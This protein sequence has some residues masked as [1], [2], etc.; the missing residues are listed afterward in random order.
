MTVTHVTDFVCIPGLVATLTSDP[1]PDHPGHSGILGA[2]AGAFGPFAT[3]A[4]AHAAAT[5]A[6]FPTSIVIPRITRA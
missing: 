2:H 1:H 5:A 4:E 3:E 6:G